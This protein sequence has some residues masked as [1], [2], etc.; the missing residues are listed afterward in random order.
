[1]KQH[2]LTLENTIDRFVNFEINGLQS[3]SNDT[4]NLKNKL[5]EFGVTISAEINVSCGYDKI[6]VNIIGKSNKNLTDNLSTIISEIFPTSTNCIEK[7][8]F[9][10]ELSY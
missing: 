3:I 10:I 9:V 4:N 2:I 5:L 6:Y 7:N 1:L 8:S